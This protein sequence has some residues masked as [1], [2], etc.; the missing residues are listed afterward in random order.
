MPS[1]AELKEILEKINISP[2]KKLGQSFLL[3]EKTASKIINASNLTKKDLV[4]EVG[5]GL[6]ALT[7]EL[8]D[9]AGKIIAIEKDE[10]LANYLKNIFGG[11]N[12][13]KIVEGDI[14]TSIPVLVQGLAPRRGTGYK[15]IANLPFNISKRIIKLFLEADDPPQ[16]MV[17]LVQKE[18]AE[19]ICSQPPHMDFLGVAVRFYAEPKYISNVRKSSFWPQ[20][21]TE[22]AIIKIKVCRL[23]GGKAGPQSTNPELFFKIAKAGFAHKR[24]QLANNFSSGL[25]IDKKK[26]VK[27]LEKA[28]ISP[29]QRA[30]T[31]DI[32]D[33]IYLTD[34]F[35]Y[36]S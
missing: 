6:G 10:K 12:N 32:K 24:K 9:K 15:V 14:L 18:V 29:Q 26:V 22:G 5:P 35:N 19:S 11:L 16:E 36:V 21:K 27:W 7:A 3:S 30:Q 23:P 8:A 25:G 34:T 13:V 4:I 20:P 31:L 2:S 33:W 1:R 17:L 28:K